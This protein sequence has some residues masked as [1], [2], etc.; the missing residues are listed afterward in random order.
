MLNLYPF[1]Q[2]HYHRPQFYQVYS[3]QAW[4][5]WVVVNVIIIIISVIVILHPPGAR[6]VQV[7]VMSSH[8]RDPQRPEAGSSKRIQGARQEATTLM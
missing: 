1:H 8:P 3:E 4:V 6:M 2:H 5:A 7:W